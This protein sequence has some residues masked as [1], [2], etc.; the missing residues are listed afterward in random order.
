MRRLSVLGLVILGI[1]ACSAAGEQATV[2][3][4][5]VASAE[6]ELIIVWDG[7]G[8]EEIGSVAIWRADEEASGDADRSLVGE[9]ELGQRNLEE[10]LLA[11]SAV[12]DPPALEPGLDYWAAAVPAGDTENLSAVQFSLDEVAELVPGEV[13]LGPETDRVVGQLGD[14]ADC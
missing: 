10:K 5:G 1:S 7:C 12:T 4:T 6:G 2:G 8:E 9:W 11:P 3:Y 13:L 14:S